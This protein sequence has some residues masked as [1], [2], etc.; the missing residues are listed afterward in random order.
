MTG[1]KRYINEGKPYYKRML[2][3][4]I[5]IMIQNGITNFV[6][7]L[8]NIMVGRIGTLEMTGVSIVNQ[9]MLV[10]GLCVFGAMSGV[11]IFTAQFYGKKDDKG[12]R[13][14]LQLK[15]ILSFVISA[16]ALLIFL[17]MSDTFIGAYIDKGSDPEDILKVTSFAK[18]YLNIMLIGGL[19]FAVTQAYA[20]TLRE[21]SDRITPMVATV[22]AV[23]V[24]LVL[25]YCL[26]F[27]HFGFPELGVKGAATATVIAR[28]T[29]LSILVVRAHVSKKKYPFMKGF[30]SKL[31]LDGKMIKKIILVAVPLMVNEGLWSGGMAF[32]NQCYSVRGLDVVAATNILSTL[33]NVF[34]VSFIA[35]GSA[36]GIILSQMLGANEKKQAK[37]SSEKML[38]FSVAVV[39]VI[40][41]VM[42]CFA[43]VFPKIYNTG[44]TVRSLA[45]SLIL[46]T[47]CFFPVHAFT[48]ACYFTLRSGGNTFITFLFDSG[49]VC[50]VC[51][52]VAFIISRYT[53]M[54]ILPFYILIQSI[55]I[56]KC[57]VGYYFMKKGKWLNTVV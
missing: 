51:A 3:V 28:F 39:V 24:N 31:S 55:D 35:L 12:I 32:L 16:V 15:L 13:S 56:L 34:N 54:N 17:T 2:A 20:G 26:I 6:S 9:L 43:P 50:T 42:A 47:S 36:I 21:T 41:A 27:G 23:F 33:T 57:I 30:F 49:F 4:A 11:G 1:I 29:E 38:V 7:M 18:S 10:F 25:N 8:D 14:T 44:E 40:G 45:C 48:N 46:I 22:I 5:P 52:P 19:P 37:E 53:D